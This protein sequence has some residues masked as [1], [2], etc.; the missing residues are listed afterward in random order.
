MAHQ[1]SEIKDKGGIKSIDTEEHV[2]GDISTVKYKVIYGNNTTEDGTFNL[3]KENGDW[4]LQ[5]GMNK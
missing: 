4:K 1:T 5:A 3:R 2:T